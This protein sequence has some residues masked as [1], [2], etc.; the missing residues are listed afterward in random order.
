MTKALDVYIPSKLFDLVPETRL[1]YTKTDSLLGCVDRIRRFNS[2]ERV[3]PGEVIIKVRKGKAVFEGFGPRYDFFRGRRLE[4]TSD[5]FVQVTLSVWSDFEPVIPR[6]QE[7]PISIVFMTVLGDLRT[8]ELSLKDNE[9]ES[10]SFTGKNMHVLTYTQ[11]GPATA[12][13]TKGYL[14]TCK[15]RILWDGPTLTKEQIEQLRLEDK[16]IPKRVDWLRTFLMYTLLKQ[17]NPN[18]NF[19]SSSK[20]LTA[21]AIFEQQLVPART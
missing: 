14:V 4:Y 17:P 9:I 10:L 2:G 20:P 11:D 5:H 12:T 15:N 7:F 18:G 21:K 8:Q 6:M 3:N 1:S 19:S 13:L 16:G